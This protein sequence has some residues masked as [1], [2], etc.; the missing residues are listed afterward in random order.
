MNHITEGLFLGRH[1]I[2]KTNFDIEMTMSHK[3][4]SLKKSH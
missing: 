3:Y 4:D 1:E 2:R